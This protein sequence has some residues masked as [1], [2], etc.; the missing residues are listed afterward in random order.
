MNYVY[1]LRD[2]CAFEAYEA[3]Y[4]R[5]I[6]LGYGIACTYQQTNQKP[7]FGA[8][9]GGS[10]TSAVSGS[11]SKFICYCKWTPDIYLTN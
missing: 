7:S 5:F 3:H 10:L 1:K 11:S 9:A 8:V 4:P 2:E 6:F